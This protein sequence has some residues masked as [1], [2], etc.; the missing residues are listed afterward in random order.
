MREPRAVLR[1]FG[2]ELPENVAVHVHDSTADLRQVKEL[3]HIGWGDNVVRSM[4]AGLVSSVL[5]VAL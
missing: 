5:Y 4:L 3:R 1:E 2:T